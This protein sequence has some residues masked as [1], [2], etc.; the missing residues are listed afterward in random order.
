VAELAAGPRHAAH[1]LDY[2]RRGGLPVLVAEAGL[3]SRA[4]RPTA[5]GAV[6]IAVLIPL[7]S[8]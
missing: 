3:E 2:L 5:G 4:V 1:S 6:T 8:T 7:T